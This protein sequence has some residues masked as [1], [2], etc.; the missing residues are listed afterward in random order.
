MYK[1]LV[2]PS[3]STQSVFITTTNNLILVRKM[4][5][6]CCENDIKH[7]E[8]NVQLNTEFLNVMANGIYTVAIIGSYMVNLNETYIHTYTHSMYPEHVMKTAVCGTSHKYT[9]LQ[10]KIL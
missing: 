8:N 3:Q 5:E 4:I 2:R 10:C 9:N 6:V 7:Y 1:H